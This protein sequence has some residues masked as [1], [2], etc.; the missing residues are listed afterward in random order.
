V[1]SKRDFIVEFCP[2]LKYFGGSAHC[3]KQGGAGTASKRRSFGLLSSKLLL[4]KRLAAFWR[5]GVRLFQFEVRLLA[6]KI[7]FSNKMI[8]TFF[9]PTVLADEKVQKSS[10]ESF[11]LL[12]TQNCL[13][14]VM[15][16]DSS[17]LLPGI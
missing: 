5:F 17:L 10:P 8:R 15:H 7:E 4:L 12:F 13:F 14:D 3:Q 2:R 1:G 16:R 11:C 6:R 9:L